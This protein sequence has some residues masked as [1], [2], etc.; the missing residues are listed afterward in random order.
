MRTA[1]PWCPV[2]SWRRDT[3]GHYPLW[4]VSV[5]DP[6]AEPAWLNAVHGQGLTPECALE[7]ML[8]VVSWWLD[9]DGRRGG[10]AADVY[11]DIRTGAAAVEATRRGQL[12]K[13]GPI[14]G[15]EDSDPPF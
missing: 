12:G 7:S 15:S 5:R 14:H 4:R 2:T 3:T 13:G 6:S 11:Q 8:S 10:T 1:F 9:Y